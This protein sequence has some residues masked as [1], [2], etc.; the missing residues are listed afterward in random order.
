MRITLVNS[1]HIPYESLSF[2]FCVVVSTLKENGIE[3]NIIDYN[4]LKKI[5]DLD[6]LFSTHDINQY[7]YFSKIS[8]E[9]ETALDKISSLINTEIV[10]F[11]CFS[12]ESLK[13]SLLLAK[14][15]KSIDPN[16]KIIFGG[17]G[18]FNHEQELMNDFSFIDFIVMKKGEHQFCELIKNIKNKKSFKKIPNL[19]FRNKYGVTKLNKIEGY[20]IDSQ[21]C[22]N[23][24]FYY[25]IK[26]DLT[27]QY[28]T[29]EGCV[30]KCRFCGL[31]N[32]KPQYKNVSKVI[33][34]IKH[35]RARY[36]CNQ[37]CFQDDNINT[38]HKRTI[39]L[40]DALKKIDVEWYAL[41][42]ANLM[43][44]KVIKKMSEAGCRWI[45]FGLESGS[46]R[47]LKLMNKPVNLKKF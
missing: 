1:E 2:G 13:Q 10:G 3:P 32:K 28:M 33:N 43:T 45:Q 18:T 16:K 46:K 11:S 15:I 30:N 40:M 4:Y 39:V 6:I 21:L 5:G 37:F 27:L 19:V 17:I 38:N 22:P 24:D 26:K 47:V 9:M 7:L 25:N 35:L 20:N 31:T 41:A 34:E 29:S 42:S 12:F 23:Y 8:V 14:Y 36:N 44:K